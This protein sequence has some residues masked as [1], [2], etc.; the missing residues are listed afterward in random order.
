MQKT[1]EYVKIKN[2]LR[3]NISSLSWKINST[4]EMIMKNVW[5]K[6]VKFFVEHA[7]AKWV[8]IAVAAVVVGGATAGIALGGKTPSSSNSSSSSSS[9]NQHTHVYNQEVAESKYLQADAT[10]TSP[11]TYYKSCVCGEKGTE[12]FTYG[13]ALEHPYSDEWTNNTTYHWHA[14]T[15]G[16]DAAKDKAVHTLDATNTCTACSYVMQEATDGVEYTL[17]EDGTYAYVSDCTADVSHVDI[18]AIYQGVPVT[19]LGDSAFRKCYHLHT[20]TLPDGITLIDTQ[21]FRQCSNLESIVLPEGVTTIADGAFADCG[22]LN[23]ITI[24]SS[25]TSIG[26]DA[27]Q[28]CNFLVDIYITDLSA[29]CKI[30]GLVSLTDSS[31]SRYNHLYLNNQLI[32][33]LV[34]PSDVTNISRFA[35]NKCADITSVTIH[36]NV[37]E[38]GEFA[39]AYCTFLADV[40]LPAKLTTIERAT[41]KWCNSLTT[42]TLPASVTTISEEAFRECSFLKTVVLPAN[43]QHIGKNAF[44]LCSYLT[45]LV[46]PETVTYIGGDAF[47]GCSSL[48]YSE[49]AN[50]AYLGSASNPYMLLLYVTDTQLQT[51]TIHEQTRFINAYAFENC[52]NLTSITIPDN[53]AL[54]DDFTF[55]NFSSLQSIVIPKSVTSIGISLF[56]FCTN[57]TSITFKGTVAEW[58]AIQKGSSWNNNVPATQVVCEDGSVAI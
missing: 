8:A 43:L 37:T 21:A 56:N 41:F 44:R 27:F 5:Q 13:E 11:A 19:V 40:S 16:C 26:E 28:H 36:D 34:I 47:R 51:Y 48:T 4:G 10:C 42:V 20:I 53:V 35:F 33:N 52:S 50:S 7:W 29:W 23:S 30:E 45:D 55:H 3:K 49:Y 6:I 39:F 17:S 38:I 32:T 57:L 31:T 1:S 25:L 9:G 54:L 12:A 22:G 15:C 14:A 2:K 46:L 24:P 18:A 58:N